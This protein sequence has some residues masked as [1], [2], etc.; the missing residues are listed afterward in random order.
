MPLL[1]DFFNWFWGWAEVEKRK[2]LED[3]H[4]ATNVSPYSSPCCKVPTKEK[5]D[6]LKKRKHTVIHQVEVNSD[7]DIRYFQ[8]VYE[9]N[10]KAR[11]VP[12]RGRNGRTV[13]TRNKNKH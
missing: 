6:L 1:T 8:E 12:V 2:A 11:K 9:K 7:D 5:I 13:K 4:P 3:L 10:K